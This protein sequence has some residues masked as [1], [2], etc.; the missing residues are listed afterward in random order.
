MTLE[1]QTLFDQAIE[2]QSKVKNSEAIAFYKTINEKG[3][4]S[5]AVELNKASLYEKEE[6]WGLA[7]NSLDRAQFL[8]RS[9]WLQSEKL[10]NIQK[11]IGS[12]RAYSIGSLGELSQ[13]I[14][15]IIR[16][17]ESMFLA[18]LLLGV[19]FLVRALGFK[20]RG[21]FFCIVAAV[22]LCSL[23]VIAYSTDKT[24]Y[25]L[26]DAELKKLPIAESTSKFNVGKGAKVTVLSK[27]GVFTKI[28]R[29][30]DFEGW[31]ESSALEE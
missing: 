7:L 21:Y 26:K 6:E 11:Q 13:E 14:S 12:N 31:V 27:K 5:V 19:Y 23:S 15:K 3:Y 10:Q 4:T 29:P 18:S 9:P 8:A 28:E 24:A 22:F 2:A 25:L 1:L 30:N 20:N 16:P 17:A